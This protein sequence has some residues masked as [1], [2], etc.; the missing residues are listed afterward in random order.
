MAPSL[1]LTIHFFERTEKE[2]FLIS[3]LCRRAVAGV[4]SAEVELF[5]ED[6]RLL[7]YATQMMMLKRWPR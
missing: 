2:W 5:D 1:D 7:A 4:A 3:G 6:G